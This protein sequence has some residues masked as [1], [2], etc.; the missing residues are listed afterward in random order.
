MTEHQQPAG[1]YPSPDPDRRDRFAR[2]WDGERWTSRE[3]PIETS[4]DA[5]ASKTEPPRGGAARRLARLAKLAIV[6]TV[7][8]LASL[9]VIYLLDTQGPMGYTFEQRASGVATLAQAPQL[10]VGSGSERTTITPFT[11]PGPGLSR[12][13]DARWTLNEPLVLEWTSGAQGEVPQ[14]FL[15]DLRDGGANVFARDRFVRVEI[16]INDTD[17]HLRVWQPTLRWLIILDRTLVLDR[18]L[19]RPTAITSPTQQAP[20][21]FIYPDST[22]VRTVLEEES[23]RFEGLTEALDLSARGSEEVLPTAVHMARIRDHA[24][25]LTAWLDATG[26]I[27]SRPASSR[28]PDMI[29]RLFVAYDDLLAALEA[30]LAY[31]RATGKIDQRAFDLPHWRAYGWPDFSPIPET[32]RLFMLEDAVAICREHDADR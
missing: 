23:E 32:V 19:D 5:A 20:S 18:T 25:E 12:I 10:S 15:I 28:F 29:E 7:A 16:T 11:T 6:V 9:F 2:Y 26:F 17:T 3:I 22:C 13:P 31:D 30:G 27:E 24:R 4:P 8:A 1:W 14:T 21:P